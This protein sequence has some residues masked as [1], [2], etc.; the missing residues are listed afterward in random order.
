MNSFDRFY[1]AISGTVPGGAV[2]FIVA[3]AVLWFILSFIFFTSKNMQRSTFFKSGLLGTMII[4]T[5]WIWL[6]FRF[7][8]PQQP[9]RFWVHPFTALSKF[10]NEAD[11]AQFSFERTLEEVIDG[12]VAFQSKYIDESIYSDDRYDTSRP[13]ET[14]VDLNLEFAVTGNFEKTQNSFLVRLIV[15]DL[16]KGKNSVKTILLSDDSPDPSQLGRKL[17]LTFWQ[18]LKLPP[19]QAEN[20]EQLS[21]ELLDV[22]FEAS[23][24]SAKED[25]ERIL[26]SGFRSEDSSQVKLWEELALLYLGW[27]YPEYKVDARYA[28]EKALSLDRRS[29]EAYYVQGV[30]AWREG[31]KL[32]ETEANFKLAYH[33]DSNHTPTLLSLA[34]LPARLLR[35]LRLWDR[36]LILKYAVK[37]RPGSPKPI[38]ALSKYYRDGL[39]YEKAVEIIEEGLK[40]NPN[41][42]QLINSHGVLEIIAANWNSGEE[43]FKKLL[44]I[45]PKLASAWYNLGIVYRGQKKYEEAREAL[46]NCINLGGPIDAYYLLGLV[47]EGMGEHDKAMSQYRKRWALRDKGEDDMA[48]KASRVRINL[49]L[50]G[51]DEGVLQPNA[52]WE[53]FV[54][55]QEFKIL[56]N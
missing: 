26:L 22:L 41:D 11:I 19:S 39:S 42:T 43:D 29:S 36:G 53:E 55:K 46:D 14:A 51:R 47:Y 49:I 28:A 30:I 5:A 35:R 25:K 38:V 16:Q 8:A 50:Q 2:P 34:Q 6:L 24:A 12:G 15:Y 1:S 32:D 33:Y 18:H 31:G 54:P 21:P 27:N 45:N 17:A 52:A 13:P 48:A 4:C 7:P 20:L 9:Y 44:S 23:E 10:Q 3:M 40:L 37:Q 56:D